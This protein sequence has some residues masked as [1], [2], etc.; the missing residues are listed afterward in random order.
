MRTTPANNATGVAITTTITAIVSEPLDAASVTSTSVLLNNGAISVPAT[1]SYTP[2]STTITLTP[3]SPLSEKTL[4]TVTLKGGVGSDRILDAAG[5]ACQRIMYGALRPGTLRPR[6]VVS[7]TPANNAINVLTTATITVELTEPLA[8]A[9]VTGTSVLLQNGHS[10]VPATLGYTPG[11]T[12]ITL[13][14][15]SPLSEKTVYTV[16]L[17]G[18]VGADRILDAAGNALSADYVWSFTTIDQTAPSPLSEKTLY[19]V[20][21]KGGLG[22]DRILDAA[23]NALSTVT[24]TPLSPLSEKTLYTVT[25][26]GGVGADRILDAAG[27]ALA[28]DYVWS[29]TTIDQTAPTGCECNTG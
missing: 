26:K 10:P 8:A 17:K 16:T 20:T 3:S 4:Y 19:T 24:L 5:N 29:F 2:G 18:G 1:L 22:S 13:T 28:A 25:L 15:L 11:S 9:S 14:P 6:A 23:G 21:L 7:A 27:N 12:T